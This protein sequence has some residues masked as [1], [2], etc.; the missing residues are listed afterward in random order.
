VL[1]AGGMEKVIE[2]DLDGDERKLMDVSISHVKE[3]VEIV[4]T[5]FPELAYA[6]TA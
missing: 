5:T 4:S 1:G 6:P 3:L 2:I